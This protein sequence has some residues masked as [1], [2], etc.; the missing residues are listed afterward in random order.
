MNKRIL[1]LTAGSQG[2]VQPYVALGVGLKQAGFEVTLA[3][4]SSFSSFVNS[5]ALD[6]AP[7]RAPFAQ[8]AQT[9]A[10]KA[11]LS[12]KKAFSLKQIIPIL[13]QMMDDAWET[14]QQFQPDAIIYHPKTLAGYHIAEKLNIPGFLAMALPAYSAT[15]AFFNPIFGGGDRGGLLNRLS[16][17]LFFKAALLPYRG[18]INTWRREKLNLQLFQ[19]DLKLRGRAI[20][21][22]YGYSPHVLPVPE[23]WDDSS[24]VTGYWFLNTAADWKPQPEL[25]AFLTQGSAPIYIGFGSMVTEDSRRVTDLVLEAV[26]QSGQ[27]AILATGWGGLTSSEIP[28]IVHIIQSAPHEWLFPRCSAVVH[29]GGAGTTGAGLR[30]GKPTVICPFIGDQPFWGKCIDD[31]GV[32][33]RPIPQKQLTADKL[34]A[35]IREVVSDLRM[36][37]RAEDLGM[38][39]RSENGV[40]QVVD[41]ISKRLSEDFENTRSTAA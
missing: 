24:F 26:K 38:K 4:D 31:L 16:Y 9:D 15:R 37:M 29:H 1:V 19:T 8:L 17:T 27:R 36:R 35:A 39:I 33:S 40:M 14:A 20:P 21:K 25:E 2:D 11:A 5:H 41:I 10:G 34:G 3:T 28:N 13:Q 12:G 18:M 7:I 23:D 30:A 22:L 32:G 6:F